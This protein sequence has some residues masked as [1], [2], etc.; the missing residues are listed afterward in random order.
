M[1][2]TSMMK[3]VVLGAVGFGIGGAI[4]SLL[5]MFLPVRVALPLTILIAG[6]VGGASLGVA[7]RDFR[8]VAILAGL[9]ALSLFIGLFAGLILGSFF[10]YS[11]V[12]IA[13]MVGAVVGASLGLAFDDWTTNVA[14][15]V[16]GAVGF[17]F[18]S[19]PADSLR[20]SIP[21]LRQLGEGGSIA[22]TGIIG[23]ASLGAVLGYLESRK[24][25]ERQRPRVR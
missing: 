21:L 11:V 1:R 15:A 25:A 5:I 14:L 18:G 23:G 3:F 13:A 19:L 22:I 10:N 17:G 20:F 2:A 16:G 6:A 8:R 24:L 4:G 12:L 9:G 7:L